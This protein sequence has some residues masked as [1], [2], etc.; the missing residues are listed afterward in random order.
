MHIFNS[1]RVKQVPKGCDRLPEAGACLRHGSGA[2]SWSGLAGGMEDGWQGAA[3]LREA[4]HWSRRLERVVGWGGRYEQRAGGVMQPPGG[5][6]L[7]EELPA[8]VSLWPSPMSF[9]ILGSRPSGKGPSY[10][11][12]TP[13]CCRCPLFPS[14]LRA[15]PQVAPFSLLFPSSICQC[16][17][18]AA[19]GKAQALH[20]AGELG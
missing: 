10:S 6:F 5:R 2:S 17:Q 20:P 4:P 3:R 19:E 9:S 11:P 18:A 13:K 7:G 8:S 12:A 16:L 15:H 1:N 14:S